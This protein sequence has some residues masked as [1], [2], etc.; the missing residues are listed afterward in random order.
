LRHRTGL[1]ANEGVTSELLDLEKVFAQ[2]LGEKGDF[3][4]GGFGD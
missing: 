1:D 2:L 4:A 3:S